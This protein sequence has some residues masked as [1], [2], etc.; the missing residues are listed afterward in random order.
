MGG[1]DA[2]A[3]RQ[4]LGDEHVLTD[5]EA[6]ASYLRE[7]RGAFT[8]RAAA[9]LCPAS[10]E[11]VAAVVRLCAE[12]GL[13]I[14]PQGGN[15]G[16]VGGAAPQ[17]AGEHVVVALQRMR[18]IREI[19]TDNDSITVE[20]G[21]IL[22][23]V[24]TAAADA[25]RLFP[26]SLAAE[27]SCRIGGNLA[28]NAGGLNVIHYGNT[29]DL[30]LGLEVVLANGEIW[31]GLSGLRK[32]NSGYDLKNLF[33][34]SEGT[35]GIITAASFKLFA[36]PR[37]TETAFV[38]LADVDAALDVLQ[39]L[40]SDSGDNLVACELMPRFA[41]ELTG[42]HA[43]R[44]RDPFDDSHPWYLLIEAATPAAGDWLRDAVQGALMAALEAGSA[45]DVLLADSLEQARDFWRIRENIPE[46]Q[47]REGASIKHDVSVPRARIPAF[48][49]RASRAVAEAVPGIRICAFG[50]V[51]DGNLHFN[52]TLP[53]GG[54]A[55]A[56][57]ACE[58]EL[59]RI[60]HDIVVEM[61]GSFAAEHGVGR[62]K[63][64]EM[65]RYKS[66]AA[67]WMM[68][69]VKAALDPDNR[70]NPDVILS[71]DA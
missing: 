47:T 21:A 30:C 3:F 48:V 49:A 31:H 69:R 22:A 56:F 10:T 63:P 6:M 68:R 28:T 35:L 33:I 45:R 37:Q 70:M 54:D 20:A 18:T 41:L 65:T 44:C 58:P 62:L 59:N 8:G 64:G 53:E 66:P 7:W 23:D 67:L 5:A 11:Q 42:R 17:S 4:R 2:G 25:E 60:V 19:D 46:S 43:E 39:R 9:V 26:L 52:L 36:R 14:V 51:G 1:F 15:T 55:K 34:G 29:R 40:R 57:R 61:A 13:A 24:Q 32:D 27:G 38:A 16:L 50:H 71:G 12:Q